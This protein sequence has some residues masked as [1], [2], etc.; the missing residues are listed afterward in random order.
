M[1]NI[2]KSPTINHL[3]ILSWE[4]CVRKFK[5][6]PLQQMNANIQQREREKVFNKT[7]SIRL[8]IF[9]FSSCFLHPIRFPFLLYLTLNRKWLSGKIITGE[10]CEWGRIYVW[11][12]LSLPHVS[13]VR[14]PLSFFILWRILIHKSDEF[15]WQI[16]W[17]EARKF[18]KKENNCKRNLQI[19]ILTIRIRTFKFLGTFRFFNYS[20]IYGLLIFVII[21]KIFKPF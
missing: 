14:W 21:L 1:R 10:C 5:I 8:F 6:F 12:T 16:A 17:N 13:I 18:K 11:F 19:F 7:W 15:L 9:F 3:S 2:N 4:C 20:F